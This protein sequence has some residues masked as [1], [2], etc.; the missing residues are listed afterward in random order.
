MPGYLDFADELS[1]KQT[2]SKDLSTGWIDFLVPRC[3]KQGAVFLHL[4]LA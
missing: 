2:D 1:V 3:S 4:G